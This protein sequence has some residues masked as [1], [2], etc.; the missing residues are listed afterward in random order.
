MGILGPDE[1]DLKLE[2]FSF[3]PGEQRNS[4]FKPEKIDK[5]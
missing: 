1:M 5:G 2:K 3:Q 4:E